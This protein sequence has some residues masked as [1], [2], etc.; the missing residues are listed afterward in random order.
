MNDSSIDIRT[1]GGFSI[2]GRDG[3]HF[4]RAIVLRQSIK[5]FA[6]TGMKP[7]RGVGGPQM[8][9]LAGEYTGKKYKRGQYDAAVADLSVWIETMRAALPTTV[10]GV[11]V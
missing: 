4:Y 7:T 8:L 9:T 10:D 11:A 6:A 3:V 5:M 2:T 1:G